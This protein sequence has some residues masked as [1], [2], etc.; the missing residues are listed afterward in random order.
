MQPPVLSIQIGEPLWVSTRRAWVETIGLQAGLSTYQHI[1]QAMGGYWTSN[2]GMAAGLVRGEDWLER[3]G[4]HIEV[5]DD[6]GVTCWEGFVNRIT[7]NV[8]PRQVTIGPLLSV[9][10]RCYLVYSTI[11]T[12]TEPPT[13]GMRVRAATVNSTG[14]QGR[15]GI[16]HK[17]LSTG[18]CTDADAA[19]IVNRYVGERA[20]PKASGV[21]QPGATTMAVRL[22]CLGYY[23]LLDYPY[24]QTA[25]TGEIDLS[26][27]DGTGKLQLIMAAEPNGIF[28][29]DY[30]RCADN[31]LQ[32]PAWE[33]DD[34]GAWALIKA[35]VARGDA[36][37]SRYTFGI[38]AN[39]QA[40]YAAA[41][42]DVAYLRRLTDPAGRITTPEGQDI[43][44]W[45]VLPGRWL[46]YP[47]WF[48]GRTEP[49]TRRQDGRF[50]F[51]ESVTYTA[52]MTAVTTGG[53]MDTL[54]QLLAQMGLSGV[55]G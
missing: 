34:K 52:P 39:R 23:A 19:T 17:V 25:A 7:A 32:V 9:A 13:V 30:R 37:Y 2:V 21:W 49:A 1:I 31:T 5:L 26:D 20:E 12:S 11:D 33:N 29:T 24:N 8:G 50:E 46:F 22:E 44:P 51:I 4:W 55:G 35:L 6:A 27:D 14:S 47:D 36:A 48:V 15:W 38:Y 54:P 42:T 18:G 41:P 43:P 16:R 45:N 28:S 40:V 10:N 53:D 3:L